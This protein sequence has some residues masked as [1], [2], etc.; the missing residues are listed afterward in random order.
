MRLLHC[1]VDSGQG[2]TH[3]TMNAHWADALAGDGGGSLGVALG[4]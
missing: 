4:V 1:Q 3:A 2:D